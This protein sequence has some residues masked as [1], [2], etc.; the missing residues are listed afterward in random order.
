MTRPSVLP[1]V[2][3]GT[4]AMAA[5]VVIGYFAS[6]RTPSERLVDKGT[7]LEVAEQMRR[8]LFSAAEAEKSAVMAVTD[9]D[10]NVY[11]DQARASTRKVSE[12]WSTLV[13]LLNATG[14]Q[15]ERDLL[16]Q[17]ATAFAEFQ[18]LDATILDLAVK[19]TNLK[20]SALDYGPAAEALKDVDASLRHLIDDAARGKGNNMTKVIVAAAEANS[21]AMRIGLLLPP[22]IAEESDAKM[23]ALEA[24]MSKDD[25]VV[26]QGLSALATLLPAND[27]VKRATASYQRFSETRKKILT[28]SREN[29]NVRS[30]ALS[31][32]EK[33]NA[34]AVCQDVLAA[35]EREIAAEPIPGLKD[36]RPRQLSP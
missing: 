28:L 19:N 5:L 26:R 24:S 16:S 33:R 36:L 34:T 3:A 31:L 4:A 8:D 29:T 22:H 17:F 20:A 6:A 2:I 35:L 25:Q 27:D 21:G 10:S 11:A 12:G 7:R 32:K 23:D 9:Y 13:T 14:T 30:L 1:W 18:K 15:R